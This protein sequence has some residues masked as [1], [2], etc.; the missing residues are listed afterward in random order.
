MPGHWR[1]V[2]ACLPLFIGLSDRAVAESPN[3]QVTPASH[4]E[5]SN[6]DAAGLDR[7]DFVREIMRRR[8]GDP[9]AAAQLIQLSR[10]FSPVVAGSLF[11]ELAQAHQAAGNINLAAETRVM[12]VEQFP[13]EESALSALVW[14]TRLY[15][16]S[17]VAHMHRP[18]GETADDDADRG[19]AL[20]GYQLADGIAGVPGECKSTPALVFARS[21][22]A[23]RGPGKNSYGPAFATQA[24]PRGRSVGRLRSVGG[25]ACG[26][27][28]LC[29]SEVGCALRGGGKS[30]QAGWRSG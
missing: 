8:G 17:E 7:A 2:A 4:V 3:A 27:A 5:A 26:I 20:Y 21:V 10:E 28:A 18:A 9:A 22:A 30:A 16:S 25:V 13:R 12:L 19:L 23:Q 11:D 15:A 29:V 14:L 6:T 24:H 1:V